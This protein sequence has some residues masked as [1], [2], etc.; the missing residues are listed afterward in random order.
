MTEFRLKRLTNSRLD[1]PAD[2]FSFLF[3]FQPQ[4]FIYSPAICWKTH[5]CLQ[6]VH[7]CMFLLGKQELLFPCFQL[8][9]GCFSNDKGLCE[10]V[11]PAISGLIC[12]ILF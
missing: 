11:P 3:V 12:F 2:I 8:T 4:N 9:K 5:T 6:F 7:A 1:N 10:N